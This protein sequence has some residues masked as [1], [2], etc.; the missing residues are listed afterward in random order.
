MK[1]LRRPTRREHNDDQFHRELISN[2]Q[3]PTKTQLEQILPDVIARF[4]DFRAHQNALETLAPSNAVMKANSVALVG[5]YKYK[6]PI[7]K[8]LARVIRARSEHVCPLCGEPRFPRTYDHILPKETAPEFSALFINLTPA[9]WDCNTDKGIQF[10]ENGAR[11]VIDPYADT[12]LQNEA[13]ACD[14]SAP[15]GSPV[16]TLRADDAHIGRANADLI[17]SHIRALKLQQR[18]QVYA[19]GRYRRFWRS[20][21]FGRPPVTSMSGADVDALLAREVQSSEDEYGINNWE[22]ALLRS[23][24]ANVAVKLFM[25]ATAP[26]RP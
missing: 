24:S 21:Y 2:K 4:A 19:G 12:F 6:R 3:E 22:A 10:T 8:Y 16:F 20:L 23:I 13:L 9:C 25:L 7:A 17:E 26:P 15:Y 5:L 14:I 11:V 18:F 1:Y